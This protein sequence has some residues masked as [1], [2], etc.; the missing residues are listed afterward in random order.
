MGPKDDANAVVDPRLRVYGVRHLRV[1]D[2]SIMPNIV[3]GNTNAPVIMI[4]EKAAEMI[5]EDWGVT[6]KKMG[7]SS[8]V[9]YMVYMRGNKADYD[10]W[11]EQGNPGWSYSEVLPYFKKAENNR[12]IESLNKYYHAVG[13]PLNVER[14]PY[15]DN[16]ELMMIQG[17]RELGLPVTDFNGE[18]QYGTDLAQS[19][20]LNGKRMSVNAAYITNTS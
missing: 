12:D 13:G 15:V 18:N 20:S 5:K 1:A 4:G 3:R 11:A 2:A 14:F 8:A 19:T 6:R 7:G 10:G 9:N 16:N 17:Y